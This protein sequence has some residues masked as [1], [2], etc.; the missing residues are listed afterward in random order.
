ME[1]E[2]VLVNVSRYFSGASGI[3]LPVKSQAVFDEPAYF[4]RSIP[5]HNPW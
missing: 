2:T 4:Y 3:I 1:I 5:V